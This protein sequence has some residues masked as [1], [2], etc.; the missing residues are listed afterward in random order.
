MGAF[1]PFLNEKV[2]LYGVEAGG[3]GRKMGYHAA[4]LVS[5]TQGVLHGAKTYVLQDDHGQIQETHSISA[6]L[7]YPGVGPELSHIKDTRRAR[8]VSVTDDEAV[9]AFNLLSQSEG[10]IPALEP[11]HALSYAMS[12]SKKMSKERSLVVNLSG[13]GDKDVEVVADHLGEKI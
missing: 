9:L 10:I 4:T 2:E 13:R 5:G 7:D 8:F 1:S 6:G 11:A 3:R 12:L